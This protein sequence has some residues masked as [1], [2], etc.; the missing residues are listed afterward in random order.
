[1]FGLTGVVSL[2]RLLEWSSS[3]PPL[4]GR[5]SSRGTGPSASGGAG[6]KQS[7]LVTS[8]A[9]QSSLGQSQKSASAFG[10]SVPESKSS[11]SAGGELWSLVASASRARS[12]AAAHLALV[13]TGLEAIASCVLSCPLNEDLFLQHGGTFILLDLLEVCAL[14]LEE[15]CMS[16]MCRLSKAGIQYNAPMV[17][18]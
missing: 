2:L 18:V 3:L 15:P 10:S 6:S 9:T 1:M 4:S 13:E 17:N 16:R 7:T 11:E 14:A 8:Q 12:A 5:A